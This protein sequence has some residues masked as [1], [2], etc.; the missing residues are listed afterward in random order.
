M[1]VSG[2]L[3]ITMLAGC[4]QEAAP[5]KETVDQE[6]VVAFLQNE[7]ITLQEYSGYA[8]DFIA[9]AGMKFATAYNADVND[10]DFWN[11]EFE[12]ETPLL[13]VKKQAE[14]RMR[15]EKGMQ[16]LAKQLG[17]KESVNWTDQQKEFAAENEARR[18][19]A[20]KGE[21]IYGPLQFTR[22][23][24]GSYWQ[25]G[26]EQMVEDHVKKNLVNPTKAEVEECYERNEPKMSR[27]N[28]S[29]KVGVFS[30]MPDGAQPD[31]GQLEF[32]LEQKMSPQEIADRLNVTYDEY[33]VN[34]REMGKEN[35]DYQAVVELLRTAEEGQLTGTFNLQGAQGWMLVLQKEYEEVGELEQNWA[36]FEDLCR[37]EQTQQYIERQI[38][39]M[40]LEYTEQYEKVGIEQ[41]RSW[42]E[43]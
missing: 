43:N 15:A 35:S 33:T 20:E 26:V 30:W 32:L 16:I 4:K 14:E 29:A 11:T 23:Q 41:L 36:E 19:K 39:N 9:Q 18:Q 38:Q 13:W 28:F 10:A 42:A 27:M 1:I 31:K 37:T 7:P 24:F 2:L 40:P 21:V 3:T 22:A 6:P 34:T 5:I 8:Y 25:S 17:L 12:G